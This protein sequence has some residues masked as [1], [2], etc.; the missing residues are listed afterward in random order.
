MNN[1]EII[2]TLKSVIE[3]IGEGNV[4]Q[5]I[6]EALKKADVPV[7]KEKESEIDTTTRNFRDA[8]YGEDI[9]SRDLQKKIVE[10]QKVYYWLRVYMKDEMEIG[11]GDKVIFKYVPSGEE[12]EGT[13]ACYSKSTKNTDED[14]TVQWIPEEDKKVL[15]IMID[16]EEIN[17]PIRSVKYPFIR[18]LFKGSKWYDHSLMRREEFEI[19]SSNKPIN[20]YDIDF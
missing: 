5:D 16:L 11:A 17:D 12:L 3:A 20:Y 2:D 1:S 19:S 14:A 8:Q 18:T 15:C 6:M 9:F 13:F 10:S 4:P 7:D